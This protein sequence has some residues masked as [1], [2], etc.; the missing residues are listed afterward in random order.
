[1]F[2]YCHVRL[3]ICFFVIMPLFLFL[4]KT[5]FVKLDWRGVWRGKQVQILRNSYKT[6]LLIDGKEVCGSTFS[7]K[8][9]TADFEDPVHGTVSTFMNKQ[10]D[11]L[12]EEADYQLVLD[13]EFVP[14]IQVPT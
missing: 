12:R 7:K 14:P 11:L 4:T 13:G 10:A 9:I 8:A 2:E 3:C 6:S 5:I 1:M